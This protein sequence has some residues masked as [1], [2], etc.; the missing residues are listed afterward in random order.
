MKKGVL[1]CMKWIWI[2]I[3]VVVLFATLHFYDGKPNSDAELLLAYGMLT[4]SF[5]C[6]ILLSAIVGAIGYLF[7]I[8]YGNVIHTTYLS[9]LITWLC[10]FVTGYIQWF[11]FVPWLLRRWGGNKETP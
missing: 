1:A 4:L 10:F 7:Y 2:T 5:P 8:T 11:K 6:S 9:I 3:S